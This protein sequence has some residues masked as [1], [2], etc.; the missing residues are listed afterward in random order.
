[1]RHAA[2]PAPSPCSPR[3]PKACRCAPSSLPPSAFGTKGSSHS[4]F[5]S[6]NYHEIGGYVE[7]RGEANDDRN[8][9]TF[10]EFGDA[11]RQTERG[12]LAEGMGFE[13]TIR[14]LTV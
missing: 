7:I 9:F 13:P 5:R 6:P 14:M 10:Q 11:W 8:A 3:P 4:P 12:G 1:R 2:P